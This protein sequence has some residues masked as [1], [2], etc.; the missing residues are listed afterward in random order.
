MGNTVGDGAA[1]GRNVGTAMLHGVKDTLDETGGAFE[2]L[3]KEYIKVW[4]D[5]ADTFGLPDGAAVGDGLKH[6]FESVKHLAEKGDG[7]VKNA[8][9]VALKWLTAS[10]N[11]PKIGKLKKI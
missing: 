9:K 10:R 2:D 11:F 7:L 4:D 5:V 8:V 6:F 1:S 3:G